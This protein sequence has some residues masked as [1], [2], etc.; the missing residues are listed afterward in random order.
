MRIDGIS[1]VAVILIASFAVDR[2]TTGTLFFLSMI[3]PW[4]RLFP[5]PETIPEPA[6]RIKEE[7]KQKML[8]FSL[9]AV[10]SAL[11]IAYFGKVRIFQ[12]LGFPT[13]PILDSIITGLVLVAGA[14]RLSGVWQLGAFGKGGPVKQPPIEIKGRLVLEEKEPGKKTAAVEKAA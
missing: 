10:F 3:K 8:F 11:V 2:I 5:D 9:A 7:K 12:A 6:G 13:N 14:D 4:N 1:A